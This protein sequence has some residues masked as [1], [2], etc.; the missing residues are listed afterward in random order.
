VRRFVGAD[1]H[2]AINDAW[3]AVQ[4]VSEGVG[5]AAGIYARRAV[6]QMEVAVGRIDK[7]GFVSDVADPAA[8]HRRG[9]TVIDNTSTIIWK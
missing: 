4:V 8:R 9:A 6:L 3:V 1:V 2:G 7:K 5:I